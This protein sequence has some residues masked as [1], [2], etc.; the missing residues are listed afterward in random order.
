MGQDRAAPRRPRRTA[1]HGARVRSRRCPA[2]SASTVHVPTPDQRDRRARDL[3]DAAA[4]LRSLRS[5]PAGPEPAT[6]ADAV[7]R[8][9]HDRV[10]RAA[11][12]LKAIACG[13]RPT[14]TACC[15][16]ASLNF[17]LPGWCGLDRRRCRRWR[18]ETVDP[19]TLQ[20]SF[21]PAIAYFTGSPEL[22]LRQRRRTSRRRSRD[23]GRSRGE[24]HRLRA[25]RATASVRG[26]NGTIGSPP[27][28]AAGR[29]G[30]RFDGAAAGGVAAPGRQ[31]A[32]DGRGGLGSSHREATK[33]R[34]RRRR[35]RRGRSRTARG[36][37]LARAAAPIAEGGRREQAL[38][39]GETE[40]GRGIP[41][42]LLPVLVAAV[43][44]PEHR[45]LE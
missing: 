11:T 13:A 44:D 15:A 22:A 9:A 27:G 1:A 4:C 37:R 25:Q 12:M 38:G 3:A 28:A 32:D 29:G 5:R 43:V 20:T 26:A 10:W 7:A 30:T 14:R 45:A 21:L 24:L 19:E 35:A 18:K 39:V 34:S 16:V 33:A 23:S 8:T 2:C 31:R 6:A 42:A 40:H 17:A 36:R 41:G